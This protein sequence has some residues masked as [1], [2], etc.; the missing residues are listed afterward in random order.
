MIPTLEQ[1]MDTN[2]GEELEALQGEEGTDINEDLDFTSTYCTK[3][4]KT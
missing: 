1:F 3:R 4:L 2:S